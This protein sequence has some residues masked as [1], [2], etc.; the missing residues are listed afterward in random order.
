MNKKDLPPEASQPAFK[1]FSDLGS[2]CLLYEDSLQR[3]RTLA[4]FFQAAVE[5]NARMVCL[6]DADQQVA[7][8]SVLQRQGSE[9]GTYRNDFSV[10]E[11]EAA[12]RLSFVSLATFS[13]GKSVPLADWLQKAKMDAKTSGLTGLWVFCEMDSVSLPMVSCWL[14]ESIPGLDKFI[15]DGDFFFL[16]AFNCH[17][18]PA[19][20]ILKA[21]PLYP[22]IVHGGQ[23]LCNAYYQPFIRNSSMPAT[24]TIIER[25]WHRM[26]LVDG[27]Q[28]TKDHQRPYSRHQVLD[29][30]FEAA[31]IGLWLLDNNHRMVFTNKN[32]CKATGVSAESFLQA[33]HYS[34]V[35]KPEEVVKCMLSD[36][37]AFNADKPIQCEEQLTFTDGSLHTY[38]IAKT[39]VLDEKKQVVGLLGLAVDITERKQAEEENRR[40]SAI[41]EGINRIFEEALTCET[42]KELG[43]VCLRVGE[44]LTQSRF[45]FIGLLR[46]GR[47]DHVAMSDPGWDTCRMSDKS[48]HGRPSLSFKVRGFFG[49]LVHTGEGFFT[50]DPALHPESIGLPKGHPPLGAFLGVPLVFAGETFGVIGLA[51]R[52]G[53]Y[54]EEDLES[55]RALSMAMVQAFRHKRMEI[56]L[57]ENEGRF[58][59]MTNGLPQLVWVLNADGRQEFINRTYCDYFGV[60]REEMTGEGCQKLV[61]P[62]DKPAYIENLLT[63]LDNHRPFYAEVRVRRSDG[64][65]RWLESWGQPQFDERGDFSGYFGVSIDITERKQAKEVLKE[66]KEAAEEASRAKSEFL[67]NMSHEIRTPMTVFLAA[68]E[69]LLQIDG[70]PDR[71][72]LLEMADNSARRLHA[73]M[74]DILDFSRIEARRVEI[75]EEPFDLRGCIEAAV[76]LFALSVRQKNLRLETDVATDIPQVVIGDAFRLGQVLTNLVGN[77]VKFTEEGEI[78][79]SVK[80]R[81]EFLE[82]SVADTGIGIPED[83]CNLIFDS[84]SQADGSLTRRHGGTGLGLAICR[85]LVELMGGDIGVLCKKGGGSIFT[86][87]LPLKSDRQCREYS[88]V[89]PDDS[90]EDRT[91]ARILLADDEPLIRQMI[92]LMLEGHGWQVETAESGREALEKWHAGN[93]DIILMDLQMPEMDGLESTRMIRQKEAETGHTT[94]IGLTA[95]ARSEIREKCLKAG[96]DKVLVKPIRIKELYSAIEGCLGG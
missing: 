7:I 93:F 40:Q 86:F 54:R 13:A 2:F 12:D 45:G 37:L 19:R 1:D 96:M 33:R 62:D 36:A 94:I 8:R 21:L 80:D 50:N 89:M 51:N 34:E 43:Q 63:C 77:A 18:L 70:D 17:T 20:L 9:H 67:A 83:K 65:W 15:L 88:Q 60:S 44:E 28:T 5:Q 42:E 48:G 69:H 27:K 41:L 91:V 79:V 66:A 85:S 73:L 68:L 90:L 6:C 61:H 75:E 59:E 52:E 22:T 82:F 35:M 56:S 57:R 38:Q 72:I 81:G 46:E 31:P 26:D 32:F 87:T 74:D 30:I 23:I 29:A 49:R 4:A 78:R 25:L 3:E 24:S 55:L 11:L 71:R 53:G 95:H 76:G 14:G 47:I 16:S 58:R 84:F 39:K 92:I 64:Q 10:P